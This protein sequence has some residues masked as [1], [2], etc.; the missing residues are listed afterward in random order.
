MLLSPIVPRNP[1]PAPRA[2]SAA[3]CHQSSWCSTWR[4]AL[5]CIV[6]VLVTATTRLIQAQPAG[7]GHDAASNSESRLV[8][9]EVLQRVDPVYPERAL[10]E[11]RT[12]EVVLQLD[13]DEL[14]N[15]T[16]A[17]VAQGAGFGM[18]EAAQQAALQLTFKPAMRANTP[19]KSR[20]LY[21]MT[22][23]LHPVER[24]SNDSVDNEQATAPTASIRG[25]VRLEQFEAPCVGAMVEM[26][27]A[28]GS[29]MRT[30]TDTNGAWEFAQVPA[31]RAVV[32][33]VA[34]GYEPLRSEEALAAG[35]RIEIKYR[36]HSTDGAIE[37]VV[38]G[39]RVDREVTRRTVERKE[40][41]V[42][43]GTGGDALKS[44]MSLPGVARTPVYGGLIVVRGSSPHGTQTFVD[45]TQVPEIY[46]LGGLSSIVPTE[47]ID[48]IDFYPG[49][50]SA[51][52]GRASGGIIDVKLRDMDYDGKYHGMAQVDMIDARLM[53]RG[54]VPLAKGWAFDFGARR[55][56]IDVWINSVLGKDAGV[57]LTPVYYDWQ[58]FAE[59]KP[60]SRSVFRIGMFGSD[61]RFDMVLTDAI[62]SDPSIGT[63]FQDK[64]RT[65][66]F[67]A[68]YRNQISDALSVNATASIGLDKEFSQSGAISNV[69]EDLVP[70]IFRGDLSYRLSDQLLVRVGPDIIV[71]HF[72]AN[73]FSV[74]PTEPGDIQ[75]S[76]SNQAMLHYNNRGYLSEPAAFAELEWTPT[77]RAKVLLGGRADYFGLTSR[78]DVSPRLNARYD[79]HT[80]LRR[81]TVKAGVGLFYEP[82]LV[83]QVIVPFGT[84]NLLSNRSVHSSVGLEQQITQQ[85]EVSIE[86]FH[87]Y[88]DHLVVA[89]QNTDGSNGYSNLGAG[90]VYGTETMVRWKPGG[91]F[92]GWVA[93]TMSRSVRKAAP[94]QPEVVYAYDQTHNMTVLGSYDLGRGWRLG[95]KFRYTTG[96]PYTPCLGGMLNAASG[97]YECIQ[98]STNSKRIPA[99]HQLDVRLD[100]AW[101]FKDFKLT[102]YLDVQNVYNR[103]NAEGIAYNYRYT[104]PQWETGLPIIP[105][106]G[107][108]GEL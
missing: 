21:K 18:D 3:R 12:G 77:N 100:K 69:N 25:L 61:D 53:L 20:I 76:V 30:T 68:V 93:Y 94:D 36:L 34:A 27:V 37:V 99:F 102:T 92:F 75:G 98:G 19:I 7:P 70:I 54:P 38:K 88:L 24:P 87:K 60:T 72:D 73:V 11:Q 51:K 9:P 1:R 40:L 83:T 84:P 58:A 67:Q 16:A 47:M 90:Y 33:I 97:S 108:R 44:I 74:P 2:T 85:V 29:T 71:Y 103:A 63:G 45:G 62:A 14:G 42:I 5:A 10:A 104:Q 6:A 82:P 4:T 86:A 106:L 64:T 96:N 80:G 56:H 32:Q 59:T 107:V 65:M 41:D 43:P 91:R 13:I 50:F 15:V 57:R 31:G 89:A 95:G 49:N 101:T 55:S 81:T 78:R 39:A 28:D 8:P 48:S 79:L 26:R 23:N 17:S 22:F 52:Y 66:R 46:H 35:E 105:S